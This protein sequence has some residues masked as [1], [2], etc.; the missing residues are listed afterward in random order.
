MTSLSDA[1]LFKSISHHGPHHTMGSIAWRGFR[2]KPPYAPAA[3]DVALCYDE[4]HQ[5]M[6]AKQPESADN[7][8]GQ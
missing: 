1:S 2:A 7:I 5:V 6:A 8:A 3:A 4:R